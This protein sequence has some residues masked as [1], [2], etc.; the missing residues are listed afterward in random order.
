MERRMVKVTAAEA[1]PTSP[2]ISPAMML[3][4]VAVGA[5]SREMITP[6]SSGEGRKRMS[7]S[8]SPTR[9][10]RRSLKAARETMALISPRIWGRER[11]APMMRRA[12]GR[13]IPPRI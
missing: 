9:G 1:R 7:P 11:L 10:S 12:V 3:V 5:P 6:S 8:V 4:T 13:A 2:P